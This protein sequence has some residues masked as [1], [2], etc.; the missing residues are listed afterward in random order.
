MAGLKYPLGESMADQLRAR[1][2][3]PLDEITV[4]TCAAGALHRE[5]I[6][7]DAETL[8]LQAEVARGAGRPQLAEN[9]E[10]AAEMVAMP[11]ELIFEIYDMLRPGRARNQAELLAIAERLRRDYGAEKLPRL[12]EDAAAVYEQRQLFRPRYK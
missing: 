7:I 10:R 1:S 5:D 9:L 4:E 6:A 2:R 8:R 11:A 3:R 12:I